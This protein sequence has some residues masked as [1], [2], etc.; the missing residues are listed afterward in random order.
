MR[1]GTFEGLGDVYLD[2]F[3]EMDVEPLVQALSN[4]EG[5]SSA[6]HRPIHHNKHGFRRRYTSKYAQTT[7][8]L[9]QE[10]CRVVVCRL[11]LHISAAELTMRV[12]NCAT[13]FAGSRKRKDKTYEMDDHCRMLFD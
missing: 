5:D 7:Q 2:S 4:P 13:V 10:R 8:S 3:N 9:H 12:S 6:P 1:I 11:S